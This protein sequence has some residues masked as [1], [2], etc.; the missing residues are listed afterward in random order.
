MT[1]PDRSMLISDNERKAAA[2]RLRV[3]Q[4]EGRLT[5]SDYDSRLGRVYEARTYADLDVLFADLPTAGQPQQ[6]WPGGFPQPAVG[7]VNGPAAVVHNTIVTPA[8]PVM[9]PNSGA[10][11]AGMVLGILGLVGFWI[12]FGDILLSALAVLFSVIG[13]TQTS[14]N[15]MAG[16]GRAIAGL[17]CGV[18]GLI[19]AILVVVLLASA[20]VF[21]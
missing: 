3:A 1:V 9:L 17:I 6:M 14:H 11:T 20:A 21:I 2:E 16:R 18:I 15:A 4:S 5:V 19:P 13:L 12:P 7:P 10:A 8:M